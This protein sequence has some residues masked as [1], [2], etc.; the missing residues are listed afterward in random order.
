MVWL[1]KG[2][3]LGWLARSVIVRRFELVPNR[4]D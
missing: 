1:E 4:S 3:R 2:F